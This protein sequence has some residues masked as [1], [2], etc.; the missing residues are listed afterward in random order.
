MD[1]L[2]FAEKWS[3]SIVATPAATVVV[4]CVVIVGVFVFG[5]VVGVL[6]FFVV[7]VLISS[8]SSS[9]PWS[10]SRRRFSF[11]LQKPIAMA[12]S[13]EPAGAHTRWLILRGSG[14]W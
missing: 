10:S 1:S 2:L 14:E 3:L 8:F 7:S 4:V 11:G 6:V 9:S 13:G 5:F 12:P